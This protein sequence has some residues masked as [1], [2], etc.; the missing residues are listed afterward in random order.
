[1]WGVGLFQ[2]KPHS[3]QNNIRASLEK[4]KRGS[5]VPW[6]SRPEA[7]LLGQWGVWCSWGGG[8]GEILPVLGSWALWGRQ[9]SSFSDL[10]GKT[11]ACVLAPLR[12]DGWG[13]NLGPSPP[14]PSSPGTE[15]EPPCP[16]LPCAPSLCSRPSCGSRG[17]Q[18]HPEPWMLA[19]PG[20]ELQ[21]SGM[22]EHLWESPPSMGQF[23][24][25]MSP[26]G[27]CHL[28]TA[29]V[30]TSTDPTIHTLGTALLA[31]LCCSIQDTFSMTLAI[32]V[33]P[34]M[35]PPHLG[36]PPCHYPIVVTTATTSPSIYATTPSRCPPPAAPYL[37]DFHGLSPIGAEPTLGDEPEVRAQPLGQQSRGWAA[38]G[39]REARQGDSPPLHPSLFP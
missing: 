27:H 24:V 4:K 31:S 23:S 18:G 35:L 16:L 21:Q 10:P 38:P 39:S 6:V 14:A 17:G 28:V 9:V 32:V 22:R 20:R 2:E 26:H 13:V 3:L 25:S 19:H 34:P 7:T 30:T 36:D 33:T 29:T 12:I 5:G 15:H 8:Y 1:M 11:R 37:H